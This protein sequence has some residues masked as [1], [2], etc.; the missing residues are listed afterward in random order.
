MTVSCGFLKREEINR[1]ELNRELELSCEIFFH[2]SNSQTLFIVCSRRLAVGCI[3]KYIRKMG[4][5]VTSSMDVVVLDEWP[6]PITRIVHW[7]KLIQLWKSI[8]K[9]LNVKEHNE[10]ASNRSWE[11]KGLK[12][13]LTRMNTSNEFLYKLLYDKMFISNSSNYIQSS[14]NECSIQLLLI[15]REM[16]IAL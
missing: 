5:V 12:N 2:Y 15:F 9:N 16:S 4:Q 13:C 14:S 3:K 7:L 11:Q 10:D 1:I 8:E 6:F